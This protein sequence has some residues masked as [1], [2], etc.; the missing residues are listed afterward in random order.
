MIAIMRYRAW[1][2]GGWG[3]PGSASA[4]WRRSPALIRTPGRL[5]QAALPI[6]LW[7][8]KTTD[9]EAD[10]GRLRCL[11]LAAQAGEA[12]VYSKRGCVTNFSDAARRGVT[13]ASC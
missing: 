13:Q 5:I 11:A 7:R 12:Y 3:R 1:R 9:A 4:N 6:G 2:Y 10:S 8:E